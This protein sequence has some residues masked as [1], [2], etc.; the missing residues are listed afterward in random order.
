MELKTC[1]G[2]S[3]LLFNPKMSNPGL[4][5]VIEAMCWKYQHNFNVYEFGGW[6]I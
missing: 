4:C 3:A 1:Y 2:M 5:L 6:R